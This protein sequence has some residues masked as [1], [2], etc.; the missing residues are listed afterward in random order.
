MER[1]TREAINTYVSEANEGLAG[2]QSK[3]QIP[4]ADWGNFLEGLGWVV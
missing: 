2:V 3:Y 1:F 4:Q